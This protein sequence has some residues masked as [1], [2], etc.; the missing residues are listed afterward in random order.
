MMRE[1]SI[2]MK[3][4]IPAVGS[5]E[6]SATGQTVLP[7]GSSSDEE[8]DGCG[9]DGSSESTASA[10]KRPAAVPSL[11]LLNAA[12]S[13]HKPAGNPEVGDSCRRFMLYISMWLSGRGDLICICDH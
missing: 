4:H 1:R 3:R 2:E 7:G 5:G 13:T 9:Y 6:A 11:N 10:S 8:G 12:K